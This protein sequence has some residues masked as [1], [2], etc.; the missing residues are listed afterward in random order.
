MCVRLRVSR[1]LPQ[2]SGLGTS[3]IL[4]AALVAAVA[5]VFGQDYA[6]QEEPGPLLHAVLRVEQLL[7]S[8]GGWQ[9]QIGAMLGGIK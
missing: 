6:S 2:G 9:D 1:N 4:A 7:S 5:R 3:S 8:G